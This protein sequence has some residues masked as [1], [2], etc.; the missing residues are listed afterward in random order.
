MHRLIS[1]M[2]ILA[3]FTA[4]LV[5]AQSVDHGM[6]QPRDPEAK[7]AGIGSYT[8]VTEGE[9][10][11]LE[12]FGT[13]QQPLASC[14]M[15]WLPGSTVMVCGV[16]LGKGGQFRVTWFSDGAEFEDL[17]T[18]DSFRVGTASSET[19]PDSFQLEPGQEPPAGKWNF[20]FEGSMS[21]SVAE[22]KWGRITR[23]LGLLAAEVETT[24][25]KG[26]NLRSSKGLR[27]PFGSPGEKVLL[28]GDNQFPDCSDSFGFIG[29][30]TA[31]SAS[32]CCLLASSDADFKCTIHTGSPCCANTFC[33]VGCTL[34]IFCNCSVGG[35]TWQ[36][37]PPCV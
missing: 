29:Q 31:T 1:G 20:S 37:P 23:L 19:L 32:R 30:A 11:E 25:S 36:C 7:K 3:L 6:R 34:G 12:V 28:C 24:L 17:L 18:G 2:A 27:L 13:N 8:L 33:T 5:S 9:K 26:H 21:K 16:E 4:G 15:E 22:Q 14:T 35:F 10:A